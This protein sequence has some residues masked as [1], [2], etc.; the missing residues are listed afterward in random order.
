[1]SIGVLN[2]KIPLT[3]YLRSCIWYFNGIGFLFALQLNFQ[4]LAA[5]IGLHL[6]NYLLVNDLSVA[7]AGVLKK[8]SFARQR[9]SIGYLIMMALQE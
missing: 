2:I 1:M 7:Y 3:S 4:N 5:E 8:K 9:M 6:G